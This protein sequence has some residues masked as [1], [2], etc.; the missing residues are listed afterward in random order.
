MDTLNPEIKP[1]IPWI[2]KSETSVAKTPHGTLEVFKNLVG[3][4]S[5]VAYFSPPQ[6]AKSSEF[7]GA[8]S[9]RESAKYELEKYYSSL[10]N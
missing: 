4:W 2:D 6:S 10:V 9:T 8:C 7:L 5:A 3:T 1:G